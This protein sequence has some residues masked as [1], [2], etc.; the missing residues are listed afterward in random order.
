MSKNTIIKGAFIL[1]ITGFLTR[2]IG[3]FFRI[4]LSH[5]FGEEQMGLYQLICPAPES[6]L[7]FVAWLHQKRLV[8][9]VKR[10]IPSYIRQLWPPC[11]SHSY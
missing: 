1:T 4:F 11:V 3:F 6:K 7:H 10:Q 5:S 2:V 9:N 8:A